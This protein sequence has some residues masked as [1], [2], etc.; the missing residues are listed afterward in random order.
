MQSRP[1]FHLSLSSINLEDTRSFYE[2]NFG[3]KVKRITN[4]GKGIHFD[5]FGHQLT[6]VE[7]SPER[8]IEV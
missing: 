8:H 6:F 2:N 4:S 5:F 3:C 1:I 7:V